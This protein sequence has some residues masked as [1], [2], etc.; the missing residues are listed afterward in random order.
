MRS[1][2]TA[3]GTWAPAWPTVISLGASFAASIRSSIVSYGESAGTEITPSYWVTTP[4]GMTSSTAKPTSSMSGT[5]LTAEDVV[6][7]IVNPSARAC[8]TSAEPIAPE[9]PSTF[10][11]TTETPR[12]SSKAWAIARPAMSVAPP[13]AYVT[14]IVMSSSG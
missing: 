8:A 3:P 11:T 1:N 12:E 2:S 7:A 10:S 13:A 4:I 6:M 14:I 9:A 5:R